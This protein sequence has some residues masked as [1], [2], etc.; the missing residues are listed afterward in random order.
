MRKHHSRG[1]GAR[2]AAADRLGLR[3]AGAGRGG[4]RRAGRRGSTSPTPAR[5][6]CPRRGDGHPRPGRGGREL[7][8][9]V[10]VAGLRLVD[11]GDPSVPLRVRAR[12]GAAA[13]RSDASPPAGGAARR[14]PAARSSVGKPRGQQQQRDTRPR[15][16]GARRGPA[17]PSVGI[18]SSPRPTRRRRRRRP[19]QAAPLVG[20]R[21]EPLREPVHQRDHDQ[22]GGDQGEAGADDPERR[23]ED[24]VE[25]DVDDDRGDRRREVELGAA[26]CGRGSRPAPVEGVEGDAGGDQADRLVGAEELGRGEGADDPAREQP[27]PGDDEGA[28]GDEP[29][30]GERRRRGA[31]RRRRGS[32]RR[33]AAR[34]AGSRGR[35]TLTAWENLTASA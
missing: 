8:P 31:P 6:C 34:R 10:L 22:V 29:G 2:G 4:A 35:A 20:D 24:Q 26:R 33:A 17:A 5:R 1:R 23:D 27:H 13:A 7:G 12:L 32:S 9:R 15:A 21:E 28:A 30:D 11:L 19:G 16:P 18:T 14:W 25:A 3:A